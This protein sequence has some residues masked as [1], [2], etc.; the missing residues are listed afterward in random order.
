MERPKK[1]AEARAHS[2]PDTW[3][4]SRSDEDYGVALG[5]TPSQIWNMAEDC[6]GF[7]GPRKFPDTEGVIRTEADDARR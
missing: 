6:I 4:P 3:A 2:L 7:W 5:F 1:K